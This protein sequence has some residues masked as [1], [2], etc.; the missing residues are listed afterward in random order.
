MKIK[1]EDLWVAAGLGDRSLP[2]P[3][4]VLF[5]WT[6][7]TRVSVKVSYAVARLLQKLQPEVQALS[8]GHMSLFKQYGEEIMTVPGEDDDPETFEP[9]S[10]GQQRIKDENLEEFRKEFAVLL[11]QKIEIDF[12][13]IKLPP[14]AEGLS[15]AD[16]VS[17]MTFIADPT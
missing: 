13:P 4:D 9:K 15:A 5:N 7:E 12:Q 8:E 14:L 10:T 1:L 6:K 16:I 3:L 2:A 11:E 17:L